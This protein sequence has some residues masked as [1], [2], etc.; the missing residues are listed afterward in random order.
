VLRFSILRVCRATT[1]P[2]HGL[3]GQ[4]D[5]IAEATAASFSGGRWLPDTEAGEV[6]KSI[7]RLEAMRYYDIITHS[8]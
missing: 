3:P 5:R 6:Y 7:V 8:K 2:G 4:C 1:S